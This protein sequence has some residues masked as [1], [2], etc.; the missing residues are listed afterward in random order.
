MYEGE[1]KK[2][3][4]NHLLGYFKV[5]GIP[6]APKGV[7]EINVCMD[8]NAANAL[9]VLVGVVMPGSRQSVIPV[10]EVRMPT[11]D[12]GHGWCVEALNKKCGDTQD[13][14]TVQRKA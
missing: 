4:E 6:E 11:V 12:D 2:A 7:P 8:I 9:T 14:V 3:E 13:L 10:M 5:V 1:E